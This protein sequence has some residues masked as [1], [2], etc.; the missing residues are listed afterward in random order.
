MAKDAGNVSLTLDG[1]DVSAKVLTVGA[2]DQSAE[3]VDI[4]AMG[5]SIRNLQAT[6]EQATELSVQFSV[7]DWNDALFTKLAALWAARGTAFP[8]KI[9]PT[10]GVIADTNPE[11]QFDARIIRNPL[12]DNAQPG[13]TFKRTVVFRRVTAVTV[14]VIP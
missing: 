13:Q 6:L 12:F 2:L 4:T 3:E 5:A 1:T 10:P 7:D 9:R 14:D 11:F 8:M